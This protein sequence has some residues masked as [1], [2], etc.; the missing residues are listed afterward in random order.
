MTA[1]ERSMSLR[2][3]GVVFA[4]VLLLG[5]I[6]GGV[7]IAKERSSTRGFGEVDGVRLGMTVRDLRARF[8]AGAGRWDSEVGDDIVLRWTPTPDAHGGPLAAQFEF[9]MG[10]LMAIRAD[11]PPGDLA[12][13]GAPFELSDAIVVVRDP[14]PAGAVH[15]TVVARSCPIHAKEADRL[16]HEHASR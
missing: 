7:V 9:H 13:K 3:G 14:T 12:A 6:V 4:A 16:V 8:G 2:R 1:S 5:L 10:I 11:L 15:V